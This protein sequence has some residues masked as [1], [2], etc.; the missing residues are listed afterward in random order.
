MNR[1][2]DLYPDPAPVYAK[3]IDGSYMAIPKESLPPLVLEPERPQEG[4]KPDVNAACYCTSGKP[5]G[6]CCGSGE[7]I[8][9]PPYGLFMFENYL[10]ADTVKDLRE[11]ADQRDAVRLMVV[12]DDKSTADNIV[13]VVDERQIGRAHV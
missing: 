8:R 5:F 1:V 7:A 4:F 13:R 9:L 11:F 10:D 3:L 2:S 12:D 6:L